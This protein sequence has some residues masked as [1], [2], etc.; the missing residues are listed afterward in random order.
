MFYRIPTLKN[1]DTVY[2]IYK[3]PVH[4]TPQNSERPLSNSYSSRPAVSEDISPVML[5]ICERTIRSQCFSHEAMFIIASTNCT[6]FQIASAHCIL[7]HYLFS[8]KN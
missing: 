7:E 1:K 8:L 3:S 5:Y 4:H 6:S 2:T